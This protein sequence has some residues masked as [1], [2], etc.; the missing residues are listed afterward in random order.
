M[1]CG[2]RAP[3]WFRVGP[4]DIGR[5]GILMRAV[6]GKR[7]SS[8]G[9]GGKASYKTT[10]AVLAFVDETALGGVREFVIDIHLMEKDQDLPSVLGRDILTHPSA[11][12]RL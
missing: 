7:R 5:M 6:K 8:R 3:L 11:T 10:R 2:L 9:V 12:P 1:I 4:S